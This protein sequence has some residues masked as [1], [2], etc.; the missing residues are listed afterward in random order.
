MADTT[1]TFRKLLKDEL[2][3]L[4]IKSEDLFLSDAHRLL[5]IS[6]FT[7][8]HA[9][10]GPDQG[11]DKDRL[12][13]KLLELMENCHIERDGMWA[14]SRM[15]P[16]FWRRVRASTLWTH[17]VDFEILRTLALGL[18]QGAWAHVKNPKRNRNGV[19][20]PYCKLAIAALR[21]A[22]DIEVYESHLKQPETVSEMD[23][24]EW[25]GPVYLD[26]GKRL[27]GPNRKPVT[28]PVF[29]IFRHDW[30]KNPR[31]L[32]SLSPDY[33]LTAEE[34]EFLRSLPRV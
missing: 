32:Y 13:D 24:S 16:R 25:R 7:V 21:F 34:P 33:E 6:R 20:Q 9:S 27:I 5:I 18:T 17:E 19:S 2:P 4:R 10:E 23:F 15:E 31:P 14:R 3:G 30:G 1:K 11:L 28:Q 8:L 22:H 29:P 26:N 12:H